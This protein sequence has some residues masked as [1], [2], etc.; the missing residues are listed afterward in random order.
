MNS[1]SAL[2]DLYLN[3]TTCSKSLSKALERNFWKLKL[4]P[5]AKW[6]YKPSKKI[7]DLS[8]EETKLC[9]V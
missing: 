9:M 3:P 2:S 5:W 8:D 6:A 7:S 4:L 1:V